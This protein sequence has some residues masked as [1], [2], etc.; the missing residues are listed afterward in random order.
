MM[1]GAYLLVINNDKKKQI[2]IGSLG[3]IEFEP[4]IYIYVG[5]AM[6]SLESRV[7]RH[8]SRNK[9]LRWHIDYFLMK[10][11]LIKA[12][13][14]PHKTKIEEDVAKIVKEY[15]IKSIKNFGSSDS[16]LDSHLFFVEEKSIGNIKKE[17]ERKF[18]VKLIEINKPL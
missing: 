10:N 7:K 13:L 17:I 8:F 9:K 4:G 6:N 16:S 15:S 3:K 2:E 1:K 12:I 5:S 18:K 14:I 11:K